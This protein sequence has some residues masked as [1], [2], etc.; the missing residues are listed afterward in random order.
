MEFILSEICFFLSKGTLDF[1]TVELFVLFLF[2]IFWV[3]DFWLWKIGSKSFAVSF[4]FVLAFYV[5]PVIKLC[6]G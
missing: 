5:E 1:I 3:L 4:L 6:L 2:A